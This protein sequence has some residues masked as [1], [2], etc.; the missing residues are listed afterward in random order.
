MNFDEW[1]R[2]YN[3]LNDL[4]KKL[5]YVKFNTLDCNEM[6]KCFSSMCVLRNCKDDI[7]EYFETNV[8]SRNNLYALIRN[9]DCYIDAFEIINNILL[10]VGLSN[11][12][13]CINNC[14]NNGSCIIEFRDLRSLIL[15]HPLDTNTKGIPQ[16]FL[17]DI[18]VFDICDFSNDYYDYKL[19][20]CNRDNHNS[21]K[22]KLIIKEDIEPII[23]EF[24]DSLNTLVL[25]LST[26]L[27]TLIDSTPLK[28]PI[29][30]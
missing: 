7:I 30:I 4:V 23:Q 20:M 29:D 24:I 2:L 6:V 27:N 16:P 5:G 10:G 28:Y 18:I 8:K 22:N 13:K 1:H 19:V 11:Q 15:A 17:E 25:K 26:Y 9:M 21:Y 12:T 3:E 14:F